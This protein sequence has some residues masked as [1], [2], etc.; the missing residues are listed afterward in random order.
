MEIHVLGGLELVDAHPARTGPI[1]CFRAR[2]AG[3]DGPPTHFV[4]VRWPERGGGEA[5][6]AAQFAHEADLLGRLNHPAIPALLTGRRE[7]DGVEFFAMEYFEGVP[8]SHLVFGRD[9]QPPGLTRPQAVYVAAQIADALRCVHE[10]ADVDED[11]TMRPLDAVHRD[12]TP[13]NVIVTP[14][15]N[16]ILIDF[17]IADSVLLPEAHKAPGA[18][19]LGYMAPERLRTPATADH[20]SDLFSLAVVLWEMIRGERCFAGD[21]PAAVLDAVMAFDM[22][23]VSHRITGLSSRLS[24]VLRKNLDP[25]PE[26]RF[27]RAYDVLRR[28]SQA[29]EAAEAETA[30][31]TLAERVRRALGGPA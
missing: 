21:D 12:V 28:L 1:R 19:T 2:P 24:E 5:L 15:G 29:T 14:E 7:Q 31:N 6:R 10:L 16:V 26:R 25:S 8:L 22:R 13:D 27:E 20:R 9:G 17:S 18:G 30:R 3:D 23:R 4:K 11:G